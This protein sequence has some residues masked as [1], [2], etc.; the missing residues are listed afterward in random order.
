VRAPKIMRDVY[1]QLLVE[2]GARGW[3]APR[4]PV[5]LNKPKLIWTAM[6]HAFV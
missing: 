1:G 4:R 2:L 6:R 3:A 5:H